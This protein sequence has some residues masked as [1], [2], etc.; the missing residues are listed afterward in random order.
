MKLICKTCGKEFEHTRRRVNCFE[1]SPSR[2]KYENEDER[3]KERRKQVVANVQRRREKVKKLSIEY[4]G[5]KCQI[6]GYNKCVDALEFHHLNPEEK[7]FGISSKGYTRS[8]EKVQQELDKCILLCSNC[9]REV[10][11]KEN[12][13]NKY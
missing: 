7:E 13:K 1:C 4:K 5:G 6:C 2:N 9:H 11:H 10:H 3:I 8:W 12:E